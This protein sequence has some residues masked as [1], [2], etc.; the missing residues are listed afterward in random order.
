MKFTHI[1]IVIDA[2]QFTDINNPPA[3]IIAA[4]AFSLSRSIEIHERLKR[5][6]IDIDDKERFDLIEELCKLPPPRHL[7][8]E[9]EIETKPGT[10][11]FP[12]PPERTYHLPTHR[13]ATLGCWIIKNSS[14]KGSVAFPVLLSHGEYTMIQDDYVFRKFFPEPEQPSEPVNVQLFSPNLDPAQISKDSA[15]ASFHNY[16]I[17]ASK[18]AGW[19]KYFCGRLKG[20]EIV[21]LEKAGYRVENLT[22]KRGEPSFKISW[23]NSSDEE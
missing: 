17:A 11:F 23:G 7:W 16:N 2:E 20:S 3:P 8:R 22:K 21:M 14:V 9:M 19:S 12:P 1:P 5:L 6:R 10:A 13:L 4:N 18:L 15:W